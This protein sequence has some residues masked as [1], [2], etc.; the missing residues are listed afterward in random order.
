MKNTEETKE[1]PDV[2]E[3]VR[4]ELRHELISFL[5]LLP[6][7][8]KEIFLNKRKNSLKRKR[9][10]DLTKIPGLGKIQEEG[11]LSNLPTVND[12]SSITLIQE[13]NSDRKSKIY[14]GH[15]LTYF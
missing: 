1:V 6:F 5:I 7:T 9:N 3:I 12:P 14:R 10:V 15:R 8:L 13:D 2:D 11:V 4:E